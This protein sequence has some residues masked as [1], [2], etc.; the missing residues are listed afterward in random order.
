MSTPAPSKR[1]AKRIPAPP[2]EPQDDEPTANGDDEST[3]PAAA[4]TKSPLRP[5]SW[6]E[7]QRINDSTSSFAQ[8]FRPDEKAVCIKFLD[9]HPYA[10]FRRHWI[11]STNQDGQRINRP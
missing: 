11:E 2:R 8:T 5:G 1:V 4:R 7:G 10:A 3:P 6:G 9:D